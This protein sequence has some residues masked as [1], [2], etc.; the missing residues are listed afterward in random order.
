MSISEG[1]KFRNKLVERGRQVNFLDTARAVAADAAQSDPVVAIQGGITKVF[2]GLGDFV[3]FDLALSSDIAPLGATPDASNDPVPEDLD[4]ED[5]QQEYEKR[6][7]LNALM[8]GGAVVA[9]LDIFQQSNLPTRTKEHYISLLAAGTFQQQR[10]KEQGGDNLI[11][12]DQL[13]PA[14]IVSVDHDESGVAQIYA[15]AVDGAVLAHEAAKGLMELTALWG[16]PGAEDDQSTPGMFHT[17]NAALRAEVLRRTDRPEH[18]LEDILRGIVLW[19]D[20]FGKGIGP[21][22]LREFQDLCCLPAA[23]FNAA[24]AAQAK[25]LQPAPDVSADPLQLAAMRDENFRAN[26]EIKTTLNDQILAHA[27]LPTD[28]AART[29][30]I[31]WM[32]GAHLRNYLAAQPGG[33]VALT[34]PDMNNQLKHIIDYLHAALTDKDLPDQY[35]LTEA[36]LEGST[37]EVLAA[38]AEKWMAWQ[39]RQ[40]FEG[41]LEAGRDY[42]VVMELA[43]G[44]RLVELKTSLALDYEG[45]K[46]GHCIGGTYDERLNGSGGYRQYSLWDAKGLP[47]C[48]FEVNNNTLQQCQGKKNQPPVARYVSYVMAPVL[49][50]NWKLG[51]IPAARTGLV[52][53]RGGQ[54]YSVHDLPEVFDGNLNLDGLQTGVRLPRHVKGSVVARSAAWVDVSRTEKIDGDLN[55]YG[56]PMV[57]TTTAHLRAIQVKGETTW[58]L[59]VISDKRGR[60]YSAYDLCDEVFDGDVDLSGTNVATLGQRCKQI[61]GDVFNGAALIDTGV[62]EEIGG[63]IRGCHALQSTS[64]RKIGGNL[65]GLLAL[66][67]ADYLEEVGKSVLILPLLSDAPRLRRVGKNFYLNSTALTQAHPDL[68]IG[69]IKD[70]ELSAPPQPKSSLLQQFFIHKPQPAPINDASSLIARRAAKSGRLEIRGDEL[71]ELMQI[72]RSGDILPDKTL[73]AAKMGN[74][75]SLITTPKQLPNYVSWDELTKDSSEHDIE[76]QHI[77]IHAQFIKQG[78]NDHGSTEWYLPTMTGKDDKDECWALYQASDKGA[79]K[80]VFDKSGSFPASV[81]WSARRY[82]YNSAYLQWMDVGSQD[83]SFRDEELPVGPVRRIPLCPKGEALTI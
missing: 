20:H 9:A 64:V 7:T 24:F 57:K 2:G 27:N 83:V 58:P 54:I 39:S 82:L 49:K 19:V 72:Q 65:A 6:R 42:N 45:Q 59:G 81:V 66:A 47:H 74:G 41:V 5:L 11:D 69:C 12:Y 38:K 35:A 33:A 79:L 61:T 18:E 4:G 16:L 50:Q 78:A 80:G 55:V 48:T 10:L 76:A 15:R 32:T 73:L 3:D 52:T 46:M 71:A 22:T 31:G 75:D 53:D 60:I 44:M 77:N 23:E 13:P 21:E 67:K 56:R 62:V 43:D 26:N 30:I 8:Q 34:T 29:A 37:Y 40:E 63:D 17:Y 28:E 36:A 1:R 51:D 14:G 70:A 25:V 68:Q